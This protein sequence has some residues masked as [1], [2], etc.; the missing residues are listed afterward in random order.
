MYTQDC[1]ALALLPDVLSG[2]LTSMAFTEPFMCVLGLIDFRVNL[3]RRAGPRFT[4][5]LDSGRAPRLAF[6]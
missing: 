6:L 1:K 5:E 3:G 4:A 2:V